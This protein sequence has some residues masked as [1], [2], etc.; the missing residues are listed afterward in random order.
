MTVGREKWLDYIHDHFLRNFILDDGCKVKFLIGPEGSGKTHLLRCIEKDARNLGYQTLF[1]DLSVYENRLHDIVSLYRQVAKSIDQQK[2]LVGLSKEIGS[3]LAFEK[4]YDGV[5]P[6]LPVMVEKGHRTLPHARG[7]IKTECAK[8]FKESD[9]CPSFG[10][11]LITIL[12]D[13]L[14]GESNRDSEVYWN[15]FR[16]EKIETIE[17][18]ETRLHDR[19]THATA[20]TW[21]YSL[22]HLIHL[23]GNTGMVL[24]I[25]GLETLTERDEITRRHRYNANAIKD[26][27]E[28]IRQLIDATDLLK[29]LLIIIAGRS[30]I[31]ERDEPRGLRSYEALWLRIQSGLIEID[32]Y[33]QYADIVMISKLIYELGGE[34]A[35]AERISQSLRQSLR[36]MGLKPKDIDFIPPLSTDSAIRRQVAQIAEL[37]EH[38]GFGNANL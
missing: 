33:N 6:I 22:I 13:H 23:A 2:I 27:Y 7:E 31:I 15:W 9:I 38:E 8:I 37:F 32:S 18:K 4:E 19:L 30:I 35:L 5:G 26:T 12:Y 20:R 3:R 34:E 11:F 24:L 25:D 17:R 21:L 29:H 28:L 36:G 14:T 16:G 10:V 1:I